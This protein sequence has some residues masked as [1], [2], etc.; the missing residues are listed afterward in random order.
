V[1]SET[2]LV[3]S[4]LIATAAFIYLATVALDKV[5]AT[6]PG[7][8]IVVFLVFIVVSTLIAGVWLLAILYAYAHLS[9][10]T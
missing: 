8:P 3:I 7:R 6:G 10:G 1:I 2:L 9:W 4:V 5:V